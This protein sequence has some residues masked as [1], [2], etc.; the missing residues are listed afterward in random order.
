M[1]P[2]G[3]CLKVTMLG[4]KQVND[5]VNLERTSSA[6]TSSDCFKS[7]ASF[8]N[9]PSVSIKITCRNEG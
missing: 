7:V 1:L 9:L 3:A 8:P 4:L 5:P 6:N 2:E